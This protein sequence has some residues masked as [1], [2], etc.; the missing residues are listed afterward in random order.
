[1]LDVLLPGPVEMLCCKAQENVG[2]RQNEVANQMTLRQGIILDYPGGF[3]MITRVLNP[4]E[5]DQRGE[6]GMGR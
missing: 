2:S 4:K 1:M 6:S 3:D 5:G